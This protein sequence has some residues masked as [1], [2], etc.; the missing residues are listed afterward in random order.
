MRPRRKVF[1]EAF[2]GETVE[3]YRQAVQS[4]SA[5]KS[6]LKWAHD[7]LNEYFGVVEIHGKIKLAYDVFT[8]CRTAIELK[9]PH[10]TL[11]PSDFKPY[12]HSNLPKSN[13]TFD[14]IQHLFTKRRSVRWYQDKDVEIEKVTEAINIASLAP[15]ACNRQPYRHII[16]KDKDTISKVANLAGGTKGFSHNIPLLIVSIGDLSA[17]PYERDR[18]LI[19]IDSSLA[20]MQLLLALQTQSI[21]SCSINWPDIK[22][23][24]EEISKAL[25]LPP[26]ERVIMLMSAGYALDDGEIPYSQKKNWE[27]ITQII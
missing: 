3:C 1:A 21:D 27:E 4:P 24:D 6:E 15:S 13:I 5:R 12:K 23:K 18:H 19:Y 25:K 16:I 11:L 9:T 20:N 7:V 10:N 17:Y 2:I 22:S 14:Q 26:H 8:S